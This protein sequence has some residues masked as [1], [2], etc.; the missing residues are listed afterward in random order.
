MNSKNLLATL[1]V[2]SADT[3]LT[4]EAARAQKRWIQNVRTVSRGNQDH[5]GVGVK[6]IHLNQKL[7]QG[8]LTLIVTATDTGTAVT[9]NRINLVNEDDCWG[10]LL[11]LLEKITHSRCTDTDKHF[12]KVR[13]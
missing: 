13:T 4:V 7:V 5:I 3:D 1:Q 9:T 10:G 11:C 12:N 6:T 2:R 8:L